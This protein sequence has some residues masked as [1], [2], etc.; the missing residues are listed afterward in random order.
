MASSPRLPRSG[1]RSD[2]GGGTIEMV[3]VLPLVFTVVLL[4]AQAAVYLHATHIAQ[5]T[6]AHA[7]AATRVQHGTV[8][9]GRAEGARVL[10]QLGRG[11]LR[12]VHLDLTRGPRLV[13]VRVYG[14]AGSVLPF[15][16]LPVRARSV[17][18][19]ETVMNGSGDT[20]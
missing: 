16:H 9:T 12:G 14:T 7:L 20:R 19:V 10:N 4:M 6:A 17:G 15:L 1:L 18:P 2:A 3:L 11:P 5:A 13:E 8:E